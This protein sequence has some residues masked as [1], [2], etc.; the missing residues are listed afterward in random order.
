M[1]GS[2]YR[3]ILKPKAKKQYDNLPPKDRQRVLGA[4]QGLRENPFV[5]K[6]LSGELRGRYAVRVWPYRIIYTI[7]KS[8]VTVTVVAIGHRK[9]VYEKA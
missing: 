6:K 8:I 1:L 4:L 2:V 7:E 3:V 5:N 9:D